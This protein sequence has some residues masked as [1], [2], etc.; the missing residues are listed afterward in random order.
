[1]YV[2][3]SIY[4]YTNTDIH[5]Y[6]YTYRPIYT[7]RYTGHA[8]HF[9]VYEAAK[10]QLGGSHTA[11]G[12]EAT[13]GQMM[14]ADMASGSLATLAH[15]GVSTPVIYVYIYRYIYTHT[16]THAH[17]YCRWTPRSIFFVYHIICS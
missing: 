10:M 12:K 7:L 2:C 9:G 1:M 4:L 17:M 5:T 11:A 15:D 14:M 13:A 16:H 6:I 3:I 8:L